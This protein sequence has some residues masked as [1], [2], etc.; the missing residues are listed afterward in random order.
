L[1]KSEI[2]KI[3]KDKGDELLASISDSAAQMNQREDKL[4]RTTRHIRTGVA[5]FIE[6]NDEIFAH[7]L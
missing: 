4:S 3:K 2:D 5:K 1:K 6:V 7:L